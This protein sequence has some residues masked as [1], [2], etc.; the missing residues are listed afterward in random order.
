M[1]KMIILFCILVL[2]LLSGCSENAECPDCICPDSECPVVECS[3][4]EADCP[5]CSLSSSVT[6]YVCPD[7]TVVDDKADCFKQEEQE[8]MVP[9]MTNEDG[10]LVKNVS[11]SPACVYGLNGGKVLFEVGSFANEIEVQA[12][13][14]GDAEFKTVLTES[15][16]FEGVRYFTIEEA[17]YPKGDFKLEPGTQY[18]VRLKFLMSSYGEPRYSN[19]HLVD[20]RTSSEFLK[21]DC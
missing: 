2:G 11:I 7:E 4:P 3:C 9:K 18:V 5:E 17:K 8:S 15:N 16:L 20:T 14:Y 21:K 10:S 12:K 6:K 13:G 1:K 19:E